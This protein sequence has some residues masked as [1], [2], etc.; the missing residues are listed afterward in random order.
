MMA[1]K[2]AHNACGSE[3]PG[4]RISRYLR[5]WLKSLTAKDS[6]LEPIIALVVASTLLEIPYYWV[7]ASAALPD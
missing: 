2:E 6:I 3:K 4:T 7:S 5:K 1:A